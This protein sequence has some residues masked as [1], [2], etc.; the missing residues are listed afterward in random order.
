MTVPINIHTCNNN[1][2]HE[3]QQIDYTLSSDN[4]LRSRTFD[5]SATSSIHLGTDCCY[6]IQ[7]CKDT[8]EKDC[9]EANWMG[10]SGSRRLQQRSACGFEYG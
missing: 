4:S 8:A 5:S 9:Q 1:G 7:S 10:M 6:Q 3:P 2:N